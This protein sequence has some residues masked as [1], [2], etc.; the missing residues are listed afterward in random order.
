[1]K[2][3]EL[4]VG[5]EV[6]VK[7]GTE[8]V[9][10][11]RAFVLATE[12]WVERRGW[13]YSARAQVRF[14]PAGQGDGQQGAAVAVLC[15]DFGGGMS[16]QPDVIQLRNLV[17][18][19]AKAEHDEQERQSRQRRDQVEEERE[20]HRAELAERLGVRHI[21]FDR[22]GTYSVSVPTATLEALLDE[23]EKYRAAEHS[24]T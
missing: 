21:H 18:V 24:T 19:G 1:M 14:R 11:S 9:Q 6:E 22:S 23:V 8:Y 5:M 10:F 3:S 2:R 17:P 4:S 12:P 15:S 13:S 20:R 16:W 7:R